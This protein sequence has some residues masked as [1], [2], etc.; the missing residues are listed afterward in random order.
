[1]F[2]CFISYRRARPWAARAVV[3]QLTSKFGPNSTFFDIDGIP[4]G[5]K[6][7]D[8]IGR[9]IRQCDVFFVTI[10]D[11]WVVDKDG[12]RRLNSEKDWVRQEIETALA[13]QIPIIPL[14]I[15]GARMPQAE[16]L[17]DSLRDLV[18]FQGVRLRNDEFKTDIDKILTELKKRADLQR[19]AQNALDVVRETWN[20]GNWGQTHN[21]LVDLSAQWGEEQGGRLMP[22]VISR[23]LATLRQLTRAAEAFSQKRFAV[24]HEI[25]QGV[26]LEDAPNNVTCSRKLAEIGARALAASESGDL[27]ALKAAETDY[28][29]TKRL[30]ITEGL[31]I[32]PGLDEVGKLF[33]EGQSDL[34]YRQ[35]VEAYQK[36]KYLQANA[37]LAGLG[38]FRDAGKIQ[39]A[40]DLW[41]AFFE[42]VRK[43]D[44]DK[45]KLVLT[46][47]GRIGD[48]AAVQRWRRWSTTVRRCL[49]AL[50]ELARAPVLLDVDVPWEG[51]ENP[52]AVL[53]VGPL[54]NSQTIQQLSFDLQAKPGGMQLQERNAWDALRVSDRRLLVDFCA[55]R[56]AN[57]RR[58]RQLVEE[59]LNVDPEAPP[60]DQSGTDLG[61][62]KSDG[63]DS[64]TQ[65]RAVADRLG[66]DAPLF[67]RALKM[68]DAALDSLEEALRATPDKPALLHHLGLVAAARA[69]SCDEEDEDTHPLWE[70]IIYAWSAIFAD[71]RFWHQWWIDRQDVYQVTKA[72]VSDAR[73][74]IQSFWFD[75][76]R[77]SSEARNDYDVLFQIETNGARAVAAGGGIPMKGG[78][79]FI[80][81]PKGVKA[82]GLHEPLAAWIATFEPDCLT[83]EGWQ[84]RVCLYFSDAAAVVTLAELGRHQAVIRAV[85]ELRSAALGDFEA[86]NPG[87]ARLAQREAYLGRLLSEFEEQAHHKLAI[88]LI[89]ESPP[90]V[91]E[92][93]ERWRT[94]LMLAERRGA[95]A[96]LSSE[97]EKVMVARSGQMLA[98]EAIDPLERMNNAITFLEAARDEGLDGETATEA[99]VEAILD[100]SVFMFNEYSNYDAA[101]SDARRA[102]TISP[103]TPRATLALYAATVRLARDKQYANR[104]DLAR[105]LLREGDELYKHS[106][107]MFPGNKS[108]DVWKQEADDLQRVREEGS[109]LTLL[110]RVLPVT[111][112]QGA[113]ASGQSAVSY[114]D[115]LMK[116]SLKDYGGAIEILKKLLQQNPTDAL[117]KTKLAVYYR[118]WALHL[119]EEKA[120]REEVKRVVEEGLK[121]CANS[122]LLSDL[123]EYAGGGAS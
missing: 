80:I 59:L 13:Q 35:A 41:I 48:P 56:V 102:W 76:V 32:V 101:R 51:G 92:A 100:R 71:D 45:G 2:K 57:H 7:P 18:E 108:M 82:L 88:D 81:G 91:Q 94:A 11:E 106:V 110:T 121:T 26:N 95:R 22:R 19:N 62:A 61:G 115:A 6:F 3:E 68:H 96:E 46:T 9:S 53:G 55:Y 52:Y 93:L 20:R 75:E 39:A 123:Y 16:D 99:L 40:C 65:V 83:K 60:P 14:L 17:P 28:A 69:A 31:E 122:D 1:M 111:N 77:T 58:A 104:P 73:H 66:E 64:R 50:E 87:F 49:G 30:T 70:K 24:A 116:E 72:Q 42:A 44:W 47:L 90:R 86:R 37:L 114:A 43:R 12:Q 113:G 74:R 120:S 21:R 117:A 98:D 119:I 78:S 109:A 84:K 118:Q 34:R 112:V 38:D 63:Q 15:G 10:D 29:A 79:H 89:T 23:R 54:A 85:A 103:R 107:A 27:V 25:L 4:V 67:F 5:E 97:V 33:A 8:V 36:G 105:Q